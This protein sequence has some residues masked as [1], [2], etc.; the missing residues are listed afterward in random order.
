M[1][2]NFGLYDQHSQTLN[3]EVSVG[4]KQLAAILKPLFYSDFNGIH[5]EYNSIC[6]KTC[7]KRKLKS[8]DY[9]YKNRPFYI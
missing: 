1:G 3:N 7:A 5:T 2:N 8:F 4:R 9:F 6:I